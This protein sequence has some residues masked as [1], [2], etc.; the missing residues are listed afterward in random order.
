MI[1]MSVFIKLIFFFLFLCLASEVVAI[2]GT[3]VEHELAMDGESRTYLV[4]KPALV[5][6]DESYP[7]MIVLHGGLG[8]ALAIKRTSAMDTIADKVPFI[9]AYPN[10]TGPKFAFNSK[11]K[12]R[13]TWNAGRCC[14]PAV[15]FNVDD[16]GF[17]S[18]M[19]DVIHEK[20]GV[21]K[22]TVY[23]A[24]FSNGAMMAYRLACE[25]PDRIAAI[26]TVSGTLSLESCANAGKVPILHLHGES[27]EHTPYNGGVGAKSRA[28][29]E[30]RSVAETVKIMTKDRNCVLS[31]KERGNGSLI[32]SFYKCESGAPFELI[33]IVGGKHV[34]PGGH[35]RFNT[36]GDGKHIFASQAAWDFASRFSK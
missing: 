8:N 10:G 27:D 22:R 28:G 18:K 15:K 32:H 31:V 33:K 24:G 29:V 6:A 34:W 4:Y 2:S 7:L 1:K 9:V 36:P 5:K 3:T 13:R 19:I 11:M 25:I 20:Y 21:D 23:V 16:V 30:H 14:G 35:G 26:V 17:I 12:N